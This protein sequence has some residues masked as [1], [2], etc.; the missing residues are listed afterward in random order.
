MAAIPAPQ[1]AKITGTDPLGPAPSSGGIEC[2]RSLYVKITY[3][4]VI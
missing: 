4:D 1:K 2:S 3:L